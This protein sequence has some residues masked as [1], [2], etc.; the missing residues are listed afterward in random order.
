[1]LVSDDER[2]LL[3]HWAGFVGGVI[4]ADALVPTASRENL[5]QDDAWR[6]VGA[7]LHQQLV[8]GL[9][10]LA[11]DEPE[12]WRLVLRRHNQQLRGSALVDDALFDLLADKLTVPTSEGELRLEEVVLRS[13][14]RILVQTEEGSGAQGVLCRALRAPIVDGR[15][16]AVLPLCREWTECRSGRLVLLGTRAG[17]SEVFPPATVTDVV[18]ARLEVLFGDDDVAVRPTR[19]EPTTLPLIL[20][21]NSEV[22][23]KRRVEADEADKRIGSALLGLA[24]AYTRTIADDAGLVVQVNLDSP[25]VRTLLESDRAH[26][27]AVGL[28]RGLAD[29][30]ASSE[31]EVW[32]EGRLEKALTGFNEAATT[33]LERGVD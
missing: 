29:L 17:D 27:A 1:M 26:S 28:L 32:G 13:S 22:Q 16:Y 6:A 12:V 4:E 24:R 3:P 19:F 8:S 33:L 25:V 31:P 5:Q 21:S 20:A 10:S 2:K 11:K 15:L 7:I 14:G 9:E 30:M 23:L 18:R